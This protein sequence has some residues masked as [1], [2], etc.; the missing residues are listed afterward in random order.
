MTRSIGRGDLLPHGPHREVDAG[1]AAPSSRRGGA[2]RGGVGV[3][4]ADR[5]VVTGVHRL[6]HVEGGRV[7]DLADDDAVGAHAQRVA[8]QV[9]DRHLAAVLD[10]RRP[11]LEPQH[12]LLVERELGG[13]LDGDD[14][15]VLGDERR[16]HV[17]GRRLAGARAAGDQD[18][19][20]PAHARGE[21][22]GDRLGEGA[23]ADQVLD[24][25]RLRGELADRQQ[26]AVERQRRDDGVDAAAVG[27]PGVDHRAGLVDAAAHL[28]DDLVDGAPQVHLVGE[29]SLH[30]EQPS[31]PLH[32]DLVRAVDH[33]LADVRVAEER[34]DG[35]VAQDVV[36]DLLGDA[37]AVGDRERG[38]LGRQD[39][40]QRQADPL[41]ELGLGELGVVELRADA[42]EQPLVHRALEGVERVDRATPAVGARGERGLG[43][44]L[45]GPRGV[46]DAARLGQAVGEAHD[47]RLQRLRQPLRT[48]AGL[49]STSVSP[50]GAE[51]LD[52]IRRLARSRRASVTGCRG[53]SRASGTPRLVEAGTSRD[54]GTSATTR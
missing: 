34:L 31:A 13:V 20:A 47:V 46:P 49:V 8:D 7:A 25:V 23:E 38:V 54:E 42:L 52:T 5:A 15:L 24:L 50:S 48:S 28:A 33:D 16:Q 12:V 14:P 22:L 37:G 44:V 2:R 19:E 41:L 30:G 36:G 27:Q 51:T 6:Q 39:V 18:V 21:E 53:C 1:H 26:R 4:R 29:V 11:R 45:A 35:A 40:L 9:A 32:E 43:R 3:D 17:E 10:V